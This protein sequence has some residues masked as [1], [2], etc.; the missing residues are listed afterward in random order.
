MMVDLLRGGG[1]PHKSTRAGQGKTAISN[2]MW[3][4]P[5]PPPAHP[6][7]PA[8][9]IPAPPERAMLAGAALVL[10]TSGTTGKPKGAV[11][12]HEAF[13][14]KLAAID[15]LL[16]FTPDTR[17]LLLLQLAFSFGQWVSLLTLAR[18]GTLVMQEKF[19]AARVLARLAVDRINRLGVIP[20]MLRA[21]LPRPRGTE[22]AA[23]L[24]AL[25]PAG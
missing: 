2:L 1:S 7:L 16:P 11:R 13:A 20:T 3:A 24:A 21:I 4:H 15:S 10:F 14:A 23:I 25:S 8:P 9:R 17:S 18:G 19:A 22:S 12:G 6:R 5:S